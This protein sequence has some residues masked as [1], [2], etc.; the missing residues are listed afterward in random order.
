MIGMQ[1]NTENNDK[2]TPKT[3][4]LQ[5]TTSEHNDKQTCFHTHMRADLLRAKSAMKRA[6]ICISGMSNRAQNSL[7]KLTRHSGR[8]GWVLTTGAFGL[9]MAF[10]QYMRTRKNA[11][12]NVSSSRKRSTLDVVVSVVFPFVATCVWAWLQ[13]AGAAKWHTSS[14]RKGASFLTMCA[15]EG[16]IKAGTMQLMQRVARRTLGAPASKL[17]C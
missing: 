4:I 5:Q 9:M 13:R 14:P 17:L 2:T 10:L 6:Q 16:L 3:K 11:F 15:C 8:K 1:Q 12:S 7:S